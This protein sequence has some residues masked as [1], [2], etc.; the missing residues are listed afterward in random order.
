MNCY[1]KKNSDFDDFKGHLVSQ[2]I[3]HFT[4]VCLV[5][6]PL[7]E[8]ETGVNVLHVHMQFIRKHLICIG[9]HM[10]SSAIWNK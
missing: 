6:W 1:F 10:I 7:N 9:N 3:D 4:V 8:S 5:S 2:L